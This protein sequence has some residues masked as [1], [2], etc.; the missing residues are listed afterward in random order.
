MQFSVGS[1]GA[2]RSSS[3]GTDPFQ[4]QQALGAACAGAAVG[5]LA[6]SRGSYRGTLRGGPSLQTCSQGVSAGDSFRGWIEGTKSD[7]GAKELQV[8]ISKGRALPSSKSSKRSPSFKSPALRFRMA[9]ERCNSRRSGEPPATCTVQRKV[10]TRAA[11]AR[12]RPAAEAKNS[13]LASSLTK[14]LDLALHGGYLDVHSFQP[15]LRRCWQSAQ[16]EMAQ[17]QLQKRDTLRA[18]GECQELVD[19]ISASEQE[20]RRLLRMVRRA[21]EGLPHEVTAGRLW[22][23]L[24]GQDSSHQQLGRALAAALWT[25]GMGRSPCCHEGHAMDVVPLHGLATGSQECLC[26]TCGTT[27]AD[28]HFEA[29]DESMREPWWKCRICCA[30]GLASFYCH[31]CGREIQKCCSYAQLLALVPTEHWRM[32]MKRLGRDRAVPP[33]GPVS[34]ERVKPSIQQGHGKQSQHDRGHRGHHGRDLVEAPPDLRPA[35]PSTVPP[36]PGLGDCD[37]GHSFGELNA[38]EAHEAHEVHRLGAPSPSSDTG[39]A[40]FFAG[41]FGQEMADGQSAPCFAATFFTDDIDDA[42]VVSWTGT[43]A[44]QLER[45]PA[46]TGETAAKAGFHQVFTGLVLSAE[47]TDIWNPPAQAT[48]HCH[49]L[50]APTPGAAACSARD[51]TPPKAQRRHDRILRRPKLPISPGLENV[52]LGGLRPVEGVRCKQRKTSARRSS[53]AVEAD[54]IAQELLERAGP[55]TEETVADGDQQRGPYVV[56]PEEMFDGSMKDMDL[57]VWQGVV[58]RWQQRIQAAERYADRRVS[59]T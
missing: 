22:Q 24:A 56:A 51:T 48:K 37:L 26:D 5:T 57:P 40:V 18:L 16:L 19:A 35:L 12:G 44:S 47:H 27:A 13:D 41:V 46:G 53:Q 4:G 15:A 32:T 58:T 55:R 31:D 36:G 42:S 6:A 21:E 8:L 1:Q 33:T 34:K 7:G 3:T 49:S 9:G 17:G 54:D 45:T 25:L 50:E 23:H 2:D 10:A 11:W 59:T 20:A 38:N 28:L 14:A 43:S 30:N 52:L 39:K 29:G